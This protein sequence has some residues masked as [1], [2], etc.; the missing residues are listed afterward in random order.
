MAIISPS[1]AAFEPCTAQ[2]GIITLPFK[3]TV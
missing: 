3:I 2:L 1:S